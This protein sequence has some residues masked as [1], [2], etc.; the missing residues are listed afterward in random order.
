MVELKC[1]L[2]HGFYSSHGEKVDTLDSKSS[3]IFCILV[4]VQ[5]RVSL[6]EEMLESGLRAVLAKYM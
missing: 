4:Q 2:F 1:F 3:A 5:L 6:F